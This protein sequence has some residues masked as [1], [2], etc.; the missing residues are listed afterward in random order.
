MEH[1]NRVVVTGNLTRD[2][3]LKTLPG[4]TSLCN[5]GL[6]CNERRKNSGTGE[7]E[8]RAN[9]F[10]VTVW[11]KQGENVAKYLTKG[12]PVAID[13][14]LSYRAWE[15]QDGSKRSAVEITADS[16]QFLGSKPSGNGNGADAEADRARA[17]ALDS[18]IPF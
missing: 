2:P 13:G 3:E 6:A 10:N 12:S 17:A 18:E 14:R 15:A 7:Y 5:V 11:G 9:F 8:D 1:I 16:V 4:G